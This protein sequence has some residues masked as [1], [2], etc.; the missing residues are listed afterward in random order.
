MKL[1]IS[2]VLPMYRQGQLVLAAKHCASSRSLARNL[3]IQE[4]LPVSQLNS[5]YRGIAQER[6]A[7]G[8]NNPGVYEL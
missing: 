3:I 4:S 6:G 5:S 7:F 1:M 2:L 8:D